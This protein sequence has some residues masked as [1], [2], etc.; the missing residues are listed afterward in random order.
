MP[1]DL[2]TRDA[3]CQRLQISRTLLQRY[4][5]TGLVAPRTVGSEVGYGRAEVRRAWAVVS[6]HRDLGINLAGVEAVFRLRAQLDAAE[7]QMRMLVDFIENSLAQQ[8]EGPEDS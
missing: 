7:R 2:L 5:Q 1:E 8:R 4:E 6:L 3:V